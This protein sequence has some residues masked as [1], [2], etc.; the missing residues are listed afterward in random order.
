MMSFLL[1]I[2]INL[3]ALSMNFSPAFQSEFTYGYETDRLALLEF[4]SKL[5]YD[6]HRALGS[7]NHSDDHCS[8]KRIKCNHEHPRRVTVLDLSDPWL[9]FNASI[10]PDIGIDD[11]SPGLQWL[12]W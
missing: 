5:T 4:H 8:W 1:I 12:L 11:S 3:V 9:R 7:W 2:C 10:P 6:P